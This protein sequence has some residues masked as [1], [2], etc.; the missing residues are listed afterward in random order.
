MRQTQGVLSR[1]KY[2]DALGSLVHFCLTCIMDDILALSDITEVE[3][4]RLSELCR[5]LHALEGLFTDDPDQVRTSPSVAPHNTHVD[6]A[7][8]CC[9]MCSRMAQILV[10]FRAFG[11]WFFLRQVETGLNV[12]LCRKPLWRTL[13]TSLTKALLSTTRHRNWSSSCA[14]SLPIHLSVQIWFTN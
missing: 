8:F 2:F 11:M 5:I 14:H 13:A 4:H 1:T 12:F 3:S 7:F 10:S 6:V 9:C